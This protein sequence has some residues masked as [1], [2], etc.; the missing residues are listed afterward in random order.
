MILDGL[1]IMVL[2]RLNLLHHL[3]PNHSNIQ[4]G[5]RYRSPLGS[6]MALELLVRLA[7]LHQRRQEAGTADMVAAYH[8]RGN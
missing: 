2:I 6:R 3:E 8:H 4:A 5:T 7:D 1:I